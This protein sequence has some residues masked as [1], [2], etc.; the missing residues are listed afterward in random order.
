[1]VIFCHFP[2]IELPKFPNI[3]SVNAFYDLAPFYQNSVFRGTFI[4][5]YFYS[6]CSFSLKFLFSSSLPLALHLI[7]S[8]NS[9]I[10]K[11]FS[12]HLEKVHFLYSYSTLLYLCYRAFWNTIYYSNYLAIFLLSLLDC[13][14]LQDKF[15]S[16][17][18][19]ELIE[20]AFYLID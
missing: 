6:C 18:V 4:S 15:Q 14:V 16:V 10:M 1:M 17:L 5:L 20:I 9:T 7:P 12:I 13:R 19:V 3:L 11:P 2:Y 8:S